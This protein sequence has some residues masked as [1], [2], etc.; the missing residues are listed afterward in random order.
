MWFKV[1]NKRSSTGQRYLV[2]CNSEVAGT[3]MI[4]ERPAQGAPAARQ[5]AELLAS[6]MN[7]TATVYGKDKDGEFVYGVYEIA[8]GAGDATNPLIKRLF[9]ESAAASLS[10]GV[11][12]SA[13]AYSS[14]GSGCAGAGSRITVTPRLRAAC[15][16]ATTHA[17]G[18]SS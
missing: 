6:T 8:D 10:F 11:M 3:M 2:R 7:V 5:A 4:E 16:A 14:G 12:M 18:T 17:I 13:A 1:E 9:A 15:A